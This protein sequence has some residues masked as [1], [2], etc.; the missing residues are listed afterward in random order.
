LKCD[1]ILQDAEGR[2]VRDADGLPCMFSER[3]VSLDKLINDGWDYPS[4][5]PSPEENVIR[6]LE[7]NMLY[8]CLGLLDSSEKE[9][10]L[11]LF[12]DG[13]TER[14]Y[15]KKLDISKTALHFRKNKIL[16]KLKKLINQ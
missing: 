5:E 12:F 14:E 11:A 6:Q 4:S 13:L 9:L 7:I 8:S 3:E 10:I 15:A 16:A 1:R 2:A